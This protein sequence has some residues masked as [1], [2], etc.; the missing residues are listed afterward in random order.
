MNV[1]VTGAAGFIGS[2]VCDHCISLGM[3][4][5]AVDDLSGGFLENIPK[6][7]D[8]VKLDIT[9]S[10]A[11]QNLFQKK[12]NFDAVYH[13]AAY[14]AEGLSHYIRHYNY[15]NNILGSINL[16]NE[17]VK[18]SVSKFIFTSSIAVYGEGQLPMSEDLTPMPEDPYGI[19]KYAVEMDL[20][21]A[22]KQ[23]GLDYIIFRPHN[24]Y[25]SRQNI[26]D[27]YRNVIGIFIKQIRDGSSLTIFG[28]GSQT[29]AFSHINDVAPY[30]AK[31]PLVDNAK[32]E[33]FNIG[34]DNPYSVIDIA[35][36]IASKLNVKANISYLPKRNEV[37]HAYSDHQKV[38]DVFNISKSIHLEEGLDEMIDWISESSIQSGTD[39]NHIE[40]TQGLPDAWK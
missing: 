15:T 28:D 18:S 1:L 40:I 16:I 6:G 27:K 2:H 21:A 26:Y 5:V 22:N 35:H 31:S 9:N 23:F 39:F 10:Q 32:N 37:L 38:K 3:N 14:A 7:V 24:V 17:S 20:V 34:S 36:T 25:G 8:F 29:R 33:I 19:S 11:V 4:V 12:G 13:I 30:I